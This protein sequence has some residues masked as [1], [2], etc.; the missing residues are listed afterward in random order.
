MTKDSHSRFYREL[1][2]EEQV[3]A[4]DLK[5]EEMA[6]TYEALFHQVEEEQEASAG[7]GERA[8]ILEAE[9]KK[10]RIQLKESQREKISLKR[11]LEAQQGSM[12]DCSVKTDELERRLDER[13]SKCRKLKAD[14][15]EIEA[16]LASAIEDKEI[17]KAKGEADE[18]S[19]QKS[20]ALRVK[21]D[22]EVKNLREQ[23]KELRDQMEAVRAEKSSETRRR[24]QEGRA[25][26]AKG[27]KVKELDSEL[28]K[29]D[30]RISELEA[31]VKELEGERTKE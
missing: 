7:I 26:K 15:D 1:H 13:E 4:L 17:L 5:L 20:A 8:V 16:T 10:C 3:R 14:Y 28:E 23:N 9:V 6:S 19:R 12:E 25:A 27:A 21:R 30:A 29:A 31:H 18:I 11:D 22:V 24:D 2:G